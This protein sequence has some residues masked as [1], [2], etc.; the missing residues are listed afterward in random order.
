[1]TNPSVAVSQASE[2]EHQEDGGHVDDHD[3][4]EHQQEEAKGSNNHIPSSFLPTQS[5]PAQLTDACSA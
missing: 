1:V 4:Q 5:R 3:T 2:N